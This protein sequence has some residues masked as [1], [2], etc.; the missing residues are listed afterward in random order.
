MEAFPPSQEFS[1]QVD[2]LAT[3]LHGRCHWRLEVVLRGMLFHLA[4]D[5]GRHGG[6]CGNGAR[7]VVLFFG[8][9]EQ[10]KPTEAS[11]VYADILLTFSATCCGRRAVVGH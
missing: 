2:S 3:A 5:H 1:Q 11:P 9:S 10:P 8:N 6:N 4:K 7:L